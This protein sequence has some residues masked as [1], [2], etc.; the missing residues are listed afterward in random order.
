MVVV[1]VVI[2]YLYGVSYVGIGTG[3]YVVVPRSDL[4]VLRIMGYP[5]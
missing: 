1:G 2:G 5:A 4:L 3:E